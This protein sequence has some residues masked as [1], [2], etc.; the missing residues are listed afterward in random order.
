MKGKLSLQLS[1][2]AASG[3]NARK[4]SPLAFWGQN[5]KFIYRLAQQILKFLLLFS[6]QCQI[7]YLVGIVWDELQ[8]VPDKFQWCLKYAQKKLT[9]SRK[10]IHLDENVKLC[11]EKKLKCGDDAIH[12]REDPK[13]AHWSKKRDWNSRVIRISYLTDEKISNDNLPSN[14]LSLERQRDACEGENMKISIPSPIAARSCC[15]GSTTMR[16][17]MR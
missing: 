6:L 17:K 5:Q 7:R 16:R 11:V 10:A 8:K 4:K 9:H 15:C 2:V 13:T 12:R 1:G 14:I 3:N